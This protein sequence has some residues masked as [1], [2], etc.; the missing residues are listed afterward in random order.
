MA[1]KSTFVKLDRNIVKWRWY[2]NP[3]TFR[4]FI[5]LIINANITDHDFENITV[6]RGEIATSYESIAKALDLSVKQVRTAIEHLKTTGEVAGKTYPKFQVIS[7][8]SYDV[9]QGDGQSKGSQEAVKGQAEGSQEAVKGQQL[10]NDKNVKNDKNEKNNIY[11]LTEEK[12]KEA[13]HK[14]GEY[15]NVLLTDKE[16]EKLKAE[17]KD[18]EKRI[19]NLSSYVEATG[20][21]YKSHYAAIRMWARN[22][23][24]KEEKNKPKEEPIIRYGGIYL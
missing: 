20:K 13:K 12:Q 11:T 24:E 4:V 6:K 9:Y 19:D 3:N 5:H 17:F 14:Y 10:K 2:K 7:I 8:L 21:I 16:F 1:E 23:R 15:G 18:Y 22:E